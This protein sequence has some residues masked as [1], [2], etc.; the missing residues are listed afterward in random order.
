MISHPSQEQIQE[1]LLAAQDFLRTHDQGLG[2]T[3]TKSQIPHYH[4]AF[5]DERLSGRPLTPPRLQ[6]IL[7]DPPA[8][9]LAMAPFLD[10]QVGTRVG[11]EPDL[12]RPVLRRHRHERHVDNERERRLRVVEVGVRVRRLGC[13]RAVG[14]RRQR[15]VARHKTQARKRAQGRAGDL[16]DD[17]I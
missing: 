11:A 9:P 1:Y 16:S 12:G 4:R 6:Q 5:L 10:G 15:C 7:L 17:W 3:L 14:R 8:C 13:R 2:G